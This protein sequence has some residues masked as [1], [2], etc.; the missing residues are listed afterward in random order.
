MSKRTNRALL[1]L[2]EV[3]FP[4]RGP[5]S[6]SGTSNDY[7]YLFQE[8]GARRIYAYTEDYNLPSQKLCKK[9][10]M[11][12]EGLFREFISFVNDVDGNPIY[13]KTTQFAILKREGCAKPHIRPGV[14]L[15][16]TVVLLRLS[17]L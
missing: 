15:S 9:L 16:L 12:Q 7:A 10:G 5:L 17:H 8:K 6:R 11:R 2:Y 4:E 3:N 1:C 14:R 13:I